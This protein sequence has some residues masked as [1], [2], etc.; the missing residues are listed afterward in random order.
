MMTGMKNYKGLDEL[1]KTDLSIS[2]IS[3]QLNLD[4]E[5]IK[6]YALKN[7]LRTK[8]QINNDSK[9]LKIL[10]F[11]YMRPDLTCY[12]ISK[13]LHVSAPFV[14]RVNDM[15]QIRDTEVT[16]KDYSFGKVHDKVL[17]YLQETDLSMAEIARIF[18]VSETYVYNIK[19]EN[20]CRMK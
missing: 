7:K 1:L 15:Y 18:K 11:L 16:K 19:K 6:H 4:E 9:F 12:K 3:K 20:K 2:T 17:S 8:S 14:Y 13:L 5:Y 10:F